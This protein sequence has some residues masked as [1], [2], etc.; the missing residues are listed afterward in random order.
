MV[1]T[2]VASRGIG[3]IICCPHPS[4]PHLSYLYLL[5]YR[6][7]VIIGALLSLSVKNVCLHTS[8]SR[9]G[10]V[11]NP[12][13]LGHPVQ[14]AMIRFLHFISGLCLDKRWHRSGVP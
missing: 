12:G 8:S 3:M 2:D 13:N 4:F 14:P 6:R 9:L 5:P 1:A 10:V 11:L 7:R